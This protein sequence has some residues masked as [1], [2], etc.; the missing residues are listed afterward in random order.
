MI[1]VFIFDLDGT[2]INSLA[3]I[4]EAVNRALDE[5]GFPRRPLGLFPQFIGE[6]VHKLV[7]R[8]V[9]GE[10]LPGIDI[11]GM[12]ADYQRHYAETW[13][14]Q[15][16]PYAGIETVIRVLRAAGM[17]TAVLSNKPDHFTKLCCDH[18][19]PA[20]SF[21]AVVGARE[22]VPRKPHPA[23]GL[24]LARQLGV[25]PEECAYVGD[26]G[27]DM[28]FAVNTGM[29]P[30]GVLWGFRGEDE[31]R[32]NGASRLVARPEEILSLLPDFI[33]PPE[34]RPR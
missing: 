14:E 2:L 32:A 28:Q 24:D 1:K 3:D 25:F 20:G 21:A 29:F 17:L 8:A 22:G 9:P 11:P 10:A 6:G 15:T 4:A 26:S 30:L 27:L 7:E 12:M 31:L 34:T 18:F 23:A 13:H 19:F 5:H 33:P 16:V